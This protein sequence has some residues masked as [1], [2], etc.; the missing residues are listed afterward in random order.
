MRRRKVWA[1]ASLL[2]FQAIA[3]ARQAGPADEATE[4]LRKFVMAR[5]KEG[6]P[7]EFGGSEEREFVSQAPVIAGRASPS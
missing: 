3:P 2:L 4:T 6:P 1:I 7:D 5:V